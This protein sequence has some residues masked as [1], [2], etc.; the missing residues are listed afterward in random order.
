MCTPLQ[1]GGH[2]LTCVARGRSE[3]GTFLCR[4]QRLRCV[5]NTLVSTLKFVHSFVSSNDR[6]TASYKPSFPQ[7]AL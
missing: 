5:E 6:P 7:S 1:E 4:M 3:T 2:Y